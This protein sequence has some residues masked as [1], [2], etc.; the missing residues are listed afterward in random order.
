MNDTGTI[1]ITVSIAITLLA[2]VG[3]VVAWIV[4]SRDR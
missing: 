2:L 3:L 4:L 1:A